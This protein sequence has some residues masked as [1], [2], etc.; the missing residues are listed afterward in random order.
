MISLRVSHVGKFAA[1]TLLL[2]ALLVLQTIDYEKSLLWC[3]VACGVIAI[4]LLIAAA[5]IGLDCR[6]DIFCFI[7]TIAFVSY[8]VVRALTSPA[9][10]SAR[11]DLYL[12]LGALTVYALVATG[13][14]GANNRIA[15][16]AL[17]LAFAVIHVLFGLIQFGV[18]QNFAVTSSLSAINVNQRASGL[19]VDPDHL[20]GLL[21][22]LGILGLSVTCWSRWPAW[23]RV[24][25]GYLTL[26]CY[27]GAALTG[28]RGAYMSIAFSL[29]LFAGLSAMTLRAGGPVVFRKYGAIGSIA[30]VASV[31]AGAFLIHQSPRLSESVAR[32]S[33]I[34]TGRIDMWHAAIEQWKLRPI[35]GTGGGTYQFYG[36]EFRTDRMQSDPADAHNDY[37]QLLGDYGLIGALLFLLFLFAHLRCGWRTFLLL[38]PERLRAG[39]LALSSRLALDI[40]ALCAIGAYAVHSAGDFNL[41]IPANALVVAFVF[42]IL[43]NPNIEL[44]GDE[45][46]SR[47]ESPV[48]F[49]FIAVAIVLLVQCARLLPGEYYADRALATLQDEKPLDAISYANQ[50]LKWEKRN[51]NIFFCLGR[52]EEALGNDKDRVEERLPF[53]E[54]ALAA[55]DQ[56][57]LLAPLDGD[58]PLDMGF[59]YDQM[60]RFTE[61]EWMYGIARSRDPRSRTVSQMYQTH[62]EEWKNSN[63]KAEN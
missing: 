40:G 36:R 3:L 13:L 19:Y 59:L 10:Y 44:R 50:A 11:S 31:A 60:G 27:F 55:F 43:A 41:H 42:G 24:I 54:R 5:T 17:L 4:A 58:H 12:A 8:I 47:Y 45:V 9:P 28:S 63:G 37:L 15:L 39:T 49:A 23:A 62:L 56:A 38:G 35:V 21:E 6:R 51:P 20:A 32:I 30:F 16:I 48:K 14:R 7:A 57:R 2:A 52:A 33:E 29:L 18:G 1:T 22:V 25:V 61:A 26:N 46:I 53:Y 34:D